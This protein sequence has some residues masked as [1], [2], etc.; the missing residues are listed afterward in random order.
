[1]NEKGTR[2][3]EEGVE[4]WRREQHL[5]DVHIKQYMGNLSATTIQST[6]AVSEYNKHCSETNE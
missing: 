4:A 3:L 6:N 1:M 2:S 5:L